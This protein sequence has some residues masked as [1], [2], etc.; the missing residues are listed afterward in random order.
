[1]SNKI[2]FS[3]EN[4]QGILRDYNLGELID[5]KP[6]E[7]G[8][9]QT[10]IFLKTTKGKFVLRYYENRSKEYVLFE[11][12]I[13][14]YFYE[15]KYPCAMPIRNIYGNFIGNF[16]EKYYAVF[17]YVGGKHI[18]KPNETKKIEIV[19]YLARLHKISKGY[20]PRYS[21]FRESHDKE[22]CITTA[23]KEYKRFDLK[24]IAKERLYYLQKQLK[25]LKFPSTIPKGVVHCD[26]DIANIKF[27]GNNIEGI[28]DFDDAC[29]TYLIY[30]IASLIYYWAWIREKKLN[31]AKAKFLL[32][33][34]NKYR[35]LSI[36]EKKYIYDA[37]KMVVLTY[38]AWFFY[39]KLRDVDIFEKSKKRLEELDKIGREEFLNQLF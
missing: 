13:L 38:M 1:M 7:S 26:F 20:K 17:K 21:E 14:H 32:N 39:D 27:K 19:K 24:E 11:V 31:F 3:K 25:S 28:L 18:K 35:K 10:N 37:L 15:H 4:I 6:F 22:Y 33:K 8:H 9:V 36:V 30:D 2:Q 5:F 34:Y 12:D 23:K 29:Y 16:K